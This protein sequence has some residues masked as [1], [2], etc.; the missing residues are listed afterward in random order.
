M[1]LW[2]NLLP[3]VAGKMP[4]APAANVVLR[5]AGGDGRRVQDD[6]EM[7]RLTYLLL[8]ILAWQA[9]TAPRSPRTREQPVT[10]MFCDIA[11]YSRLAERAGPIASHRLV[12][13]ILER[14]TDCIEA[15]GGSVVDYYGD[16]V[17]VMWN[18][19]TAQPD[20]AERACRAALATQAEVPELS[21]AWADYAETPLQVRCTLNSGP[22]LVGNTG[23]T[24]RGKYGPMGHTVNLAQRVQTASKFFGSPI[25]LTAATRTQLD[26]SSF[27][28]RRL[29]N[30][31]LP[32]MAQPTEL[33]E[34]HVAELGWSAQRDAFENALALF[35][36]GRWHDACRASHSLVD[37]PQHELDLASLRLLGRAV[38][39]LMLP[40][41]EF[42]GV[43]ELGGR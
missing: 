18:A 29:G 23:T 16:G 15:E 25:V 36:Q 38:E 21:A 12:H 34:L 20:H 6:R 3:L 5:V 1:R 13:E 2:Q 14:V 40:P 43:W 17:L 19:P 28:L 11:N 37:V 24:R 8:T 9:Q 39:H 31:R 42:A 22:A 32:S 27:A 35:E 7:Q 4:P 26:A 41:V 33:F 10:V 30:V